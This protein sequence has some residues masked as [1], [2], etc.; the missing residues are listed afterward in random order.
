MILVH[1]G[2]MVAALI[3]VLFADKQAFAW[4]RG[5][6][7]T[8]NQNTMHVLHRLTWGALALL[9][10]SGAL[11]LWPRMYL[12]EEPLFL[13]K[14]LFVGVLFTNAVLIGRLMPIALQRSYTSLTAKGKLPLF[15]SG[16]LSSG[17]WLAIVAI[18]Y[19]L[20]WPW[21]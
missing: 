16:A 20:F 3:L 15:V 8:L 7:Q 21:V 14:L 11:L 12:L 10:V 4:M 9:G 6:K 2:A 13:I 1:I 17:S 19:Y 5:K 18:A